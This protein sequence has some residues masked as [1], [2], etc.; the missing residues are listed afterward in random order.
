MDEQCADTF[1][2]LHVSCGFHLHDIEKHGQHVRAVSRPTAMLTMCF[3]L[4]DI[5]K[6][7]QHGGRA[8]DRAHGRGNF[9]TCCEGDYAA[10]S[11]K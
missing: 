2:D 5:E 6:H 7:G 11:L 3:H 8:A 1:F 9:A 10:V 4:H